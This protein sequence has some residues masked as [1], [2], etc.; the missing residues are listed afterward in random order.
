MISLQDKLMRISSHR[1]EIVAF[2]FLFFVAIFVP[3]NGI[4]STG[5][6]FV[7]AWVLF[8]ESDL[9]RA[10][11]KSIRALMA[12]VLVYFLIM[13]TYAFSVKASL[14]DGGEVLKSIAL[15]LVV[16]YILKLSEVTLRKAMQW[17][18]ICLAIS[19][20]LILAYNLQYHGVDGVLQ[21]HELD[22]YVNRNR[23]AVGFSLMFIFALT[24]VI[25]ETVK[26]KSFLLSCVMVLA[27]VAALLNDSRGAIVA[28]F[29]SSVFI[30][31]VA[32][33]KQGAKKVLRFDWLCLPTFIAA[34]ILGYVFINH[35]NLIGF[36]HHGGDITTYRSLIWQTIWGRLQSSIWVGYGPHAIMHDHFLING[37]MLTF[38]HPHSIYMGLLYSSGIVGIVFWFTWFTIY[39]SRARK[40]VYLNN[41][42]GFYIGLGI[43]VNALV[44]GL[45]DFDFY[46]LDTMTF[47]IVGITL[48]AVKSKANFKSAN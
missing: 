6:M 40:I 38:R 17:V 43:L 32:L 12:V 39:L 3:T 28:M 31:L 10:W 14:H 4:G 29:V 19:T 47:L 42:I 20:S 48:V 16:F 5:I 36:V 35:L 45:V 21:R 11:W 26:L 1:E 8:N 30:V 44:H 23:L 18:L 15:S 13:T 2:F 7:L 22:W 46:A 34:I 9:R 41:D 24:L 27:A 37:E 25:N 33:F